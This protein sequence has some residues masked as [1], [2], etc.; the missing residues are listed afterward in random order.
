MAHALMEASVET[1]VG[2][3][4]R[5]RTATRTGQRNR[6]EAMSSGRALRG[7]AWRWLLQSKWRPTC[8]LDPRATHLLARSPVSPR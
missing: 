3:A 8:G 4:P 7:T 5:E 1:H 6:S 2:V